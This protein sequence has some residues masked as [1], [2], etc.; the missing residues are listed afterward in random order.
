MITLKAAF[1]EYKD[2]LIKTKDEIQNKEKAIVKD[3]T[4]DTRKSDQINT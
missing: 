2:H 1:K 4:D 3:V